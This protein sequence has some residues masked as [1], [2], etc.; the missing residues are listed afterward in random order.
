MLHEIT[1]VPN[2]AQNKCS[3][4]WMSP[5]LPGS[6]HNSD[7]VKSQQCAL[8]A[9]FFS[10]W[11]SCFRMAGVVQVMSLWQ[12]EKRKRKD[13]HYSRLVSVRPDDTFYIH[14]S[15]RRSY[16]SA[17]ILAFLTNG[18]VEMGML[19]YLNGRAAMFPQKGKKHHARVLCHENKNGPTRPQD[20]H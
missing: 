11:S 17:H 2:L 20:S 19:I 6:C 12:T 16:G 13:S 1:Y 5:L 10:E 9:S 3:I 8:W 4:N 14:F 18:P 15:V 7:C